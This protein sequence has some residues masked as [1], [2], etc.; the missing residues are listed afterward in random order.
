MNTV[1]YVYPEH[2]CLIFMN[3]ESDGSIEENS[4]H[5]CT[6]IK[7]AS[8]LKRKMRKDVHGCRELDSMNNGSSISEE[9]IPKVKQKKLSAESDRENETSGIIEF[10]SE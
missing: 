9:C 2:N 7:N 3:A 8:C 10:E 1:L 6:L 4:D 5:N